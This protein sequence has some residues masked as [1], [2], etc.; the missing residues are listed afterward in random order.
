M[1]QEEATRK[2][3]LTIDY[4]DDN[5]RKRIQN[6][7]TSFTYTDVASGSSDSI[8]ISLANLEKKWLN[9]WMPE[10][11]DSIAARIVLRE[12]EKAGTAKS[13]HCGSFLID[14]LSFRGRPLTGTIG[15]V[16]VP[17]SKGFKATQK[18]KTWE[19]VTVKEI[20]SKIAESAGIELYYSAA[21]IKIG[22]LEQSSE[23]DSSFLY[24]LCEKYGLAMKVYSNKLVIFD[25]EEYK[26]KDK[27]AT[28]KEKDMLDWSFNT[29][30]DG[31][32]TGVKLTYTKPSTN[33]TTSVT[34]GTEERLYEYSATVEGKYDA[35][36]QAAAKLR[37]E[38]KKITTMTIKIVANP[39]IIASSVIEVTGLGKA[40]GLYY[41]DKVS[42]TVGTGYTMTL[43]VHKFADTQ[44]DTEEKA[45]SYTVK[46]GDTLTGI[47]QQFYKTGVYWRVI[48]EAN[49]QV[50]ESTAKA[51]GRKNSDNGHWI[52][53]GTVLEIPPL[54]EK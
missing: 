17:V 10:K 14:D 38:N 39:V 32:Y 49:E 9:E 44:P 54:Q 47:S 52:Y 22:E 28:I 5:L 48:W 6:H 20:A 1:A 19:D 4:Y 11:G 37:S 16:S 31:T 12:W 21:S 30:L 29:T 8:S 35:E 41:V 45:E 40:N 51:R 26:K 36:L 23:T 33:K 50:I 15:A 7:T 18:S 27:V 46:K 24:G 34:V 43:S 13:F 3:V 2:V 25:E 42:H 53:P